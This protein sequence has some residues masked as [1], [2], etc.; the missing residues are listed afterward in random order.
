MGDYGPSVST[1]PI[2]AGIPPQPSTDEHEISVLITGFGPFKT[3]NVNAS[4]L[5]AS[6]LPSSF[7]FPSPKG[8]SAS[9]RVSLHVYPTAIPVSYSTV[10]EL[11]PQ[12]LSDYSAA[13]GGRRPD[14]IIHIGIASPRPYYSVESLAHRDEYV[15]TDIDGCTGYEDGEKRWKEMG[16]PEILKP[17]L[18]PASDSSSG[19]SSVLPYPPDEHFLD[20]WKLFAPATLDLRIS[21]DAG[22][23]LCDFIFYT[24][25]SLAL[26]EGRARNVLFLHVPSASEDA[27]VERG[28]TIALALVKAMVRCWIDEKSD[29]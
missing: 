18:P 14:L 4:Y 24:S 29:A 26:Q 23:Y 17:G 6:S 20:T 2:T 3:N 28:R 21:K 15:M 7:S 1:R 19:A 22:R 5:I 10:R 9:R 11:L 13:H 27:D 25:M 8:D 12:I 16:L